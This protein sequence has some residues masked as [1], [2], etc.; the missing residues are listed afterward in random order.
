[1]EVLLLALYSLIVWLIFFKFKIL[2]WT[3]TAAVI[4][5]TL[6]IIALACL[7]LLLNVYAPAALDVQVVK[8]VV[9][10]LP[11][12]TGR[13]IEVPVEPNRLVRKGEVLFRV[14]PRPFQYEVDRLEAQLA[15]TRA[16]VG[17]MAEELKAAEAQ[18]DVSL[19]RVTSIRSSID[20]TRVRLK[21]AELRAGQTQQLAEVG[22]GDRFEAERWETDVAQQRA[23]LGALLPQL[24]AAEQEVTASR[25]RAAGLREKLEARSGNQQADVAQVRAQLDD[26]RWKLGET[27]A[28]APADGWVIN[29][30][31]RPGSTVSQLPLNPVMSFVEQEHIILALFG[32]NELH[33][34]EPGNEAEIALATYPGRIIKARVDS[35]V[36]AQGQGQL[37]LTG[38]LPQ[39]GPAPLPEG[40]FA[41]KLLLEEPNRDLFLAAGAR[42]QGAIYTH[43]LEMIHIIRKVILR[44]S[45]YLDWIIIKHHISLH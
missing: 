22:A 8:Y 30:Q 36:W 20:A 28:Y 6:P 13:V 23:D 32:Q 7:I 16:A 29:L 43:H 27:T 3:T 45:A 44:V 14:D 11:R 34:V 12:V 38:T 26:A 2:A 31:L 33:Q 1:M 39:T 25:A 10:V 24:A 21:L 18:I 35:I 17:A 19:N 40:R 41:V 4:V 9:Q 37:P 5:I 42:G 15:S